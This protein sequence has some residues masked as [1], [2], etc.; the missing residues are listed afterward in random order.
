MKYQKQVLSLLLCGALLTAPV[1]SAFAAQQEQNLSKQESVYL[2]LN[3]DG[4]VKQQTVSCWLHNDSGLK[5]IQDQ[6]NLSD[7]SNI[8]SEVEPQQNGETVTWDTADA[9]VYYNGTSQKT[10]PVSLQITYR[11]NGKTVSPEELTGQSGSLEMQIKVKNLQKQ[12]RQIDGQNRE[13][14]TPFVVGMVLDFPTEHFQ[15]VHV[16]D[17]TVISDSNNQI[18][19]LISAPGLKENFSGILTEELKSITDQLSDEF[20]IQAEVTDFAFP[21]FMAAAATNLADLKD[22]NFNDT[23]SGLEEGMDELNSASTQLLDGTGLLKDAL[24]EF[25]SKMGEFQSSYTSFDQGLISAVNGTSQLQSGVKTLNQAI[26]QLQTKMNDELVAGISGSAQLQ[27]ELVTKMESLKKTL[28]GL[29]LPDLSQIS[30]QLN[31]AISQVSD[32]SADVAV[33]VMT[34]GLTGTQKSLAELAASSNPQEQY[35]A[36]QIMKNLEPIKNQASAQISQMLSSLDLSKLEA[37]ETQL[38]EID[39]LSSKLMTGVSQ[40]TSA[41]YDPNDDLSDPK[42][43]VGAIM[44]LSLGADDLL[45]GT[46]TLSGGLNQLSSA[47]DQIENAVSQFKS[48]T[49]QLSESSGE[50]NDG[51]KQFKEEGIDELTDSDLINQVNTALAVKDAMEEQSESYGAYAGAPENAEVSSA[52]I[53]KV[54]EPEQQKDQSEN[55]SQEDQKEENFFVKIWHSITDFFADLF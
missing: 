52:F 40:L 22:M 20:T 7:L 29:K 6:T 1:T 46:Q 45:D 30:A 51:M 31:A 36:Q 28:E 8:K 14:Y 49:G 50:L 27:Q 53:M 43:V 9:D 15:N 11:L 54:T 38:Q 26:K 18:V 35:L 16:G 3:P 24:T 2:I 10:P 37:L 42:T 47:S 55:T 5:G 39:A 12:T 33:R 44:A 41:L 13:I 23:L 48:A 34:Q 17:T 4:S 21:E 32:G 19:S 25:D